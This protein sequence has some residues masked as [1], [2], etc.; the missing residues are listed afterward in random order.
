MRGRIPV[1]FKQLFA[2]VL[3]SGAAMTVN[4]T[5]GLA[6]SI[7]E[8]MAN[9][10][11]GN[12]TL[13]AERARQ[14]ATDEQVPQALSNW[15]PTVTIEGQLTY[16][17]R[18]LD[19]RANG[20]SNNGPDSVSSV[21]GELSIN[22][23][24]PLFRGFKTV[25]GV[26][27]AESNVK[28]GRQNLIAVEQQVLFQAVQ[29]YMN[30]LRDRQIVALRNRNVA[31]LREQL[32]GANE[33][34]NVGEVTKTDVAQ[35]NSRLAASQAAL[36]VARAQLAASTA[37]YQRV[38]GHKPGKL[39]YPPMAKLPKSLEAALEIS[40]KLNP[41]I[42]AAAFV[43]DAQRHA[44]E[45]AKGDL[46]PTVTLQAQAST[47]RNDF[48]RNSGL[49]FE[50]EDNLS[51]SGN[52]RFPL[53]NGGSTYSNIR[54]AKQVASQRQ[55]Q[56]LESGR[57]VREAVTASWSFVVESQAEIEA[58]KA[59]V[60]AA[61]LALE[62][63][64]QEALV[65]SRTTLDVLDAEQDVTEARISLVSAERDLI[66]AAYQVLGSIGNLNARQLGLR[67]RYYD[68]EVNYKRVR[69]KWWGADIG[70]EGDPSK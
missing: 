40:K 32:R 2:A 41:N 6:E 37:N 16:N 15:R 64:K 31:A 66:V 46:L 60:A 52:F 3:L 34:F 53:Y 30:V 39:V 23:S 56:I 57:S 59:Q 67:V 29:A 65:G 9:A 17:Y 50:S 28:A 42:L 5:A 13:K 58:A 18:D 11:S 69:D 49:A 70:G 27:Q 19:E 45:V 12:P 36:A 33:R 22:L 14:R 21:P 62:G 24:Q 10:Y 4:S 48:S 54:Q 63:V 35:A 1:Y 43:A 55:I 38:V 26:K 61:S 47:Q 51:I 8:A 44:V 20:L 7:Y 68:P 25:E